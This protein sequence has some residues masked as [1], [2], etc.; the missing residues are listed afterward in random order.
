MAVG[1]V[2]LPAGATI[3]QQL[4]VEEALFKRHPDRSY[5][6]VHHAAP[7]AVVLG[8]SGQVHRD[9]VVERV[10]ADGVPVI[11]RFSGGGTVYVDRSTLFS[12][13]ISTADF[14][15]PDQVKVF[16]REV[17]AWVGGFYRR[18]FADAH[19]EDGAVFALREND[20]HTSFLWDFEEVKLNAYLAHP[21]KQPAYRLQRPHSD[22]VCRLRDRFP[23]RSIEDMV[24]AI[25][26]AMGE[27]GVELVDVPATE[28]E[29]ALEEARAA[30]QLSSH[31]VELGLPPAA[32]DTG[33]ERRT[34]ATS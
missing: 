30:G 3:L 10:V 22:F 1:V 19:V 28:V 31:A 17:M 21:E 32:R 12:T 6:L 18:A 29:G 2:R 8:M 33:V 7:P 27:L 15:R 11:R 24:G 9:V 16:P 5:L 20:Y 13:L 4:H 25:R 26:G 23:A 34:H 14:L